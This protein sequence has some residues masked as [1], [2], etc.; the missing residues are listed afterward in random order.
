M[1]ELTEQGLWVISFIGQACS[2]SAG[3]QLDY[4]T[5][6]ACIFLCA[7]EGRYGVKHGDVAAGSKVYP[8]P[9]SHV[10]ETGS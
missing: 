10:Q 7:C 8:K 2:K 3:Y 9:Y 1:A 6:Q 4:V 5:K